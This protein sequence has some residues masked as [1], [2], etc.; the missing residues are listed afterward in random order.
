MLVAAPS[1]LGR[2][3]S[4]CCFR[5]NIETSGTLFVDYG[6]NPADS[7]NGTRSVAWNW[8][9]RE[10]VEY[11][12]DG[13]GRPSLRRPVIRSNSGVPAGRYKRG[14]SYYQ[15]YTRRGP[16]GSHEDASCDSGRHSSAWLRTHFGVHTSMRLAKETDVE[17]VADERLRGQR[18]LLAVQIQEIPSL[19]SEGC[20]SDGGHDA[21]DMEGLNGPWNVLLRPPSRTQFRRRPGF[22]KRYQQLL[23][24]DREHACLTRDLEP[25]CGL[26]PHVTNGQETAVV[27]FTWFP[28]SRLAQNIQ[29]LNA[30]R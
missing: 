16:D 22:S 5:V 1:A 3:R 4:R 2:E 27:R 14:Y 8:S 28:R 18:Y 11:V 25:G 15:T 9:A 30:L 29:R 24:L 17:E 10:I 13:R 7:L 19:L 20:V 26:Q 23:V 12:E 6:S 21:N